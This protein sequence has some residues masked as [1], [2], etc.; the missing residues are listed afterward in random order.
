MKKNA[1][2]SSW[3]T[4]I[5]AEPL[6]CLVSHEADSLCGLMGHASRNGTCSCQGRVPPLTRHET[7]SASFKL[8]LTLALAL[9]M[10]RTQHHHHTRPLR[11]SATAAT[12][13]KKTDD[14]P[15]NRSA[16]SVATTVTRQSSPAAN[17]RCVSS[18]SPS[19]SPWLA[20]DTT[21][22]RGRYVRRQQQQ[23]QKTR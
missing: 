8:S 4:R 3:D 7:I 11:A 23:R 20:H 13:T 14:K 12:T 10:A 17:T 1:S 21:T 19:P 18:P 5:L 2:T 15:A 6:L 9:T 22:M 16:A